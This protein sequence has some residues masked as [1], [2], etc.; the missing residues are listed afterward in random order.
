MGR[1]LLGA[2]DSI[3]S[4]IVAAV[5]ATESGRQSARDEALGHRE[6]PPISE[7]VSGER[8]RRQLELGSSGRIATFGE[9]VLLGVLSRSLRQ[10]VLAPLTDLASSA[11]RI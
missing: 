1:K 10:S 9:L 8:R 5:S 7:L 11:N 2:S 3:M 6:P 4:G